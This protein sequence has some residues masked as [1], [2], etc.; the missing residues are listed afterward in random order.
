[1]RDFFR[2]VKN[3][4]FGILSFLFLAV[5]CL[6]F[7]LPL[8]QGGLGMNGF[9]AFLIWVGLMF[10]FVKASTV[11]SAVIAVIILVG[12]RIAKLGISKEFIESSGELVGTLL[13][14]LFVFYIIIQLVSSFSGDGGNEPSKKSSSNRDAR[15]SQE[16]VNEQR[17]EQMKAWGQPVGSGSCPHLLR[18]EMGYYDSW[19]CYRCAVTGS[20]FDDEYCR[21]MCYYEPKYKNCSNR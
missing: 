5:C 11:G 3:I 20:T 12:G 14:G 18:I 19:N 7:S 21:H 15:Y 8:N 1:M 17:R 6:S 9:L 16:L 13:G 10:V 4:F 2:G